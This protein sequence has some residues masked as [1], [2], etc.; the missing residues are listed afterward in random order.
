MQA[1]P[2]AAP[3]A[4][5]AR[6][7]EDHRGAL[8]QFLTARCG[9]AE[10]AKDLLQELWIKVSEQQP[11]GPIANPRA[12]LFRMANN[13]V[14]DTVRGRQRAMRRDRAWIEADADGIA[15]LP[16]DRPDP[17]EPADVALVR[18]QEAEILRGA[19]DNLP[20]GAAR[21]LML[22]RFEEMGQ[23]EIAQV[24]G[25]SRSGVEKHLALAMKKLRAALAD[26][27]IFDSEASGRQGAE[28][29]TRPPMEQGQ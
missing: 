5:L 14:L 16:D 1:T 19:I 26:C 27:G 9:S 12:Y 17:A 20:E 7:I 18:R 10:E 22:Y 8:L 29:G 28:S 6:V 13:L 4:G 23:G 11:T 24:M 15:P 21:A 3:A 2:P 25:I